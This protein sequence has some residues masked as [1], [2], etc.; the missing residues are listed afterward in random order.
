VIEHVA[1]FSEF[2]CRGIVTALLREIL[3]RGRERDYRRS[4]LNML[5]GNTPARRAYE[6]AGFI[7]VEERTDEEFMRIFSTSGM[8]RMYREL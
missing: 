8:L 6:K 3:D 4:E 1:V 7:A 5:I 2:R